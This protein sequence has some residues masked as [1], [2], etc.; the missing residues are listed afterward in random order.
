MLLDLNNQL[1]FINNQLPGPRSTFVESPLQ[2][3]LFME[4]KPIFQKP[5]MNLNH[6]PT[7]NYKNL[8][9]FEKVKNKP[10]LSPYP[11]SFMNLWGN[12]PKTTRSESVLLGLIF[13]LSFLG[14]FIA[15]LGFF[16]DVVISLRKK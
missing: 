7:N 5:N 6:Y 1:S 13:K 9:L 10:N 12:E 2:I 14:F 11:D 3:H 15:W 4:N 8:H 16:S